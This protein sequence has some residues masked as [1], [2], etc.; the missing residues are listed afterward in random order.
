MKV[1]TLIA[2]VEEEDDWICLNENQGIFTMKAV[3]PFLLDK[4]D[5]FSSLGS[6]KGVVLERL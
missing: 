6:R 4:K 2:L 3:F 5:S 1:V